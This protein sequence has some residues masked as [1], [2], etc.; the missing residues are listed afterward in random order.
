VAMVYLSSESSNK[1]SMSKRHARIAGK[2]AQRVRDCV[3]D[4]SIARTYVEPEAMADD[5][6]SI[7]D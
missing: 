6:I 2:L 4:Q 1:P 3:L 5:M 7:I